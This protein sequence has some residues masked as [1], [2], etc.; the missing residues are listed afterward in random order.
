MENQNLKWHQKPLSV[1]LLLIFFFPI[2]LYFMWKNKMWSTKT[3]WIVTSVIVI[4]AIAGA[5]ND[6]KNSGGS[7]GGSSSM[8]SEYKHKQFVQNRCDNLGYKVLNLNLNSKNGCAFQ[9]IINGFDSNG[10]SLYCAMT[11]DGSSGSISVTNTACN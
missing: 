3:R 10:S 2:G 9:W 4:L 6:N 5:N 8:C 11:T 1:V 7:S